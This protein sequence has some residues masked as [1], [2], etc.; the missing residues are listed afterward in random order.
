MITM[1]RGVLLGAIL[2]KSLT[3]AHDNPE[4]NTVVSLMT[5]EIENVATGLRMTHETWVNVIE[6]ALG[7]YLLWRIVGAAAFFVLFPTLR[8]C[9]ALHL[10]LCSCL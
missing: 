10:A 5:T 6:V 7:I 4:R 8:K 2:G 1:V 3:L 9:N